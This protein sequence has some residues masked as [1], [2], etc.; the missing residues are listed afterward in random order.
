M[1]AQAQS[2]DPALGI[3][4]E[5]AKH[6]LYKPWCSYR[7][8]RNPGADGEQKTLDHCQPWAYSSTFLGILKQ[9]KSSSWPFF[10]AEAASLH[11]QPCLALYPVPLWGVGPGWM[12][13]TPRSHSIPPFHNWMGRE[14]IAKDLWDK[15]RERSLTK[16]HHRQSRLSLGIIDWIYY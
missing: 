8:Q 14:T 6:G 5:G 10:C 9:W 3:F 15:D 16:Y 1:P 13:G 4:K 12:P 11:L 7:L 2:E